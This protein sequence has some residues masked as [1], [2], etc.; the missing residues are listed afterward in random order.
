MSTP[1]TPPQLVALLQSQV[2]GALAL[3]GDGGPTQHLMAFAA[4]SSAEIWMATDV[5]SAKWRALQDDPRASLLLDDRAGLLSD[6]HDAVVATASGRLTPLEGG[7]QVSA[8]DALTARHPNLT[9]FLQAQTTAYLCFHV[10][11]WR[12]VRNFA[13]VTVFDPRISGP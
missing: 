6:H 11:N 9:T 7:A 10:H 2:Q 13:H 4:H 12:M 5:R 1:T 3:C 8:R